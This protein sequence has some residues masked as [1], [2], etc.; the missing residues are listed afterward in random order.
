MCI[1][2]IVITN[3]LAYFEA[4]AHYVDQAIPK[5][6]EIL[7][8]LPDRSFSYFLGQNPLLGA[9]YLRY[10]IKKVGKLGIILQT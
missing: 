10:K 8:L 1:T 9:V 6:P 4:G 5:S 2:L 3:L 7:L